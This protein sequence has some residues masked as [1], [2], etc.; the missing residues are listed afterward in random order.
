[1]VKGLTDRLSLVLLA[2]SVT[3]ILQSLWGPSGRASKIIVL[4]SALALSRFPPQTL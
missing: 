2:L 1:M 3:E 4:L